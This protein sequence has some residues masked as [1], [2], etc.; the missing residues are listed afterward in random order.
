MFLNFIPDVTKKIAM[1]CGLVFVFTLLPGSGE[2]VKNYLALHFY[3]SEGFFPF[4]IITHFFTHGSL[5]HLLFNMLVLIGFGGFLERLWGPKKFFLFYL[6][7]GIGSAIVMQLLMLYEQSQWI[8]TAAG[9]PY[10][11]NRL[12]GASGAIF[13][14][15]VAMYFIAPEKK[16]TLFPIPIPVSIKHFV[17][18]LII[19][20]LLLANANF[21]FD[22]VSHY[23]HLSGA[24]IGFILYKTNKF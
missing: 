6:L 4:Q 11:Y 23:G 14:M 18:F 3:K 15:M 22:N 17:P 12:V 7:T 24:L 13:G 20:E 10:L 2:V 5:L 8:S 1:L 9:Q 19:V 21:A 16:M